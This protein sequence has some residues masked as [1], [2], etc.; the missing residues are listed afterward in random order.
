MSTNDATVTTDGCQVPLQTMMESVQMKSQDKVD[1]RSVR[2]LLVHIVR[3][4]LI[5]TSE[6]L[7][8]EEP[9]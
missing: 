1:G 5:K 6:T 4:K 9:S 3:N 8:L 7:A 2:R